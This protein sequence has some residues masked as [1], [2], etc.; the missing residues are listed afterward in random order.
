MADKLWGWV[1]EDFQASEDS[2]KRELFHE[3]RAAMDAR[4]DDLETALVDL[5]AIAQKAKSGGH[6]WFEVFVLHWKLQTLLRASNNPKAALPIAARFTLDLQN[7]VFADFPQRVILHEDLISAYRQIDP[8]GH[9]ELIEKALDAMES[10]SSANVDLRLSHIGLKAHFKCALSS[11]DCIDTAFESL[12]LCDEADNELRRVQA[13]AQIC[14]TT[15]LYAPEYAREHLPMLALDAL[16]VARRLN[17]GKLMHELVMWLALGL[18]YANDENT[19]KTFNFAIDTR[20]RYNAAAN[21]GYYLATELYHIENENLEAALE[22]LNIE[23]AEIENKGEI[24]RE[25]TRRLAKCHL[26][27]ELDQDWKPDAAKIKVRA[28]ELKDSSWVSGALQEL[29]G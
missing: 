1:F 9:A 28:Q 21:A 8:I 20:Q 17:Y 2:T 16:E 19:E 12:R 13:L 3:W 26:L 10:E 22:N 14:E 5:D 18:R 4:E 23:L 24:F 29:N 6:H 7:P 11:P 27:K 15:S 25:V